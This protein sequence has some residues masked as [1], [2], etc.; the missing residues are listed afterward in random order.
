[1]RTRR[2]PRNQ[3]RLWR[4]LGDAEPEPKRVVSEVEIAR[5]LLALPYTS[6]RNKAHA[7]R[8][9]EREALRLNVQAALSRAPEGCG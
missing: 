2:S 5:Q 6:K 3:E 1:M 7:R 4:A 9:L 8:V